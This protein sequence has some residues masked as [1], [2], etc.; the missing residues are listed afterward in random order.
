MNQDKSSNGIHAQHNT[1]MAD[2]IKG[3]QTLELFT[4]IKELA[5]Q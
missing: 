1:N 3:Y 5:P 4:Q 2:L